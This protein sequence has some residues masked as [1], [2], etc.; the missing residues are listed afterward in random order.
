MQRGKSEWSGANSGQCGRDQ[1][2]AYSK[3]ISPLALVRSPSG[4]MALTLEGCFAFAY[5]PSI[6]VFAIGSKVIL[7]MCFLPSLL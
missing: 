7:R 2:K 6:E 5:E 1:C 3:W 4:G